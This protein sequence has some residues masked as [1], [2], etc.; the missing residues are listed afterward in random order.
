MLRA[1]SITWRVLVAL[2]TA[3]V[4][5]AVLEYGTTDFER[6]VIAALVLIYVTGVSTAMWIG[7]ALWEAE[8][9]NVNRF[10]ALVRRIDKG[11]VDR[12]SEQ[13]GE[14]QKQSSRGFVNLAIIGVAHLIMSLGAILQIIGLVL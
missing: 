5:L 8:V 14:L 9:A 7:R 13:L 6:L 4:G 1:L 2:F 11:D 12:Y 10:A 3:G